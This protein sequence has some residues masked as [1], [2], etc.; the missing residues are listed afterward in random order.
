[1]KYK[2][3]ILKTLQLSYFIDKDCSIDTNLICLLSCLDSMCSI[4]SHNAQKKQIIGE[5]AILKYNKRDS[6]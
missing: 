5:K 1:M 3:A 6:F 2:V 4:R